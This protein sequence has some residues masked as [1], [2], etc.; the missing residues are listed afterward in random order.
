MTGSVPW[1]AGSAP[2]RLRAP[3]GAT[4]SHHHIYDDRFA[5]DP[6]AAL[7]PGNATVADYRLLQAQIGTTRNV[8]VQ[9]SSYGTDNRCL[10]DALAGFGTAAR[11]VAVVDE[12]VTDA[13][14]RAMDAA[15]VRGVRV[16]IARAGGPSVASIEALARRVAPLGWHVQIHTLADAYPALAPVLAG[17]PV[18]V[19]IDHLGR[20]PQPEGL[21]HAAWPALRALVDT[22]RCW[23]KIS[24]AYHDSRTG[25][26]AYADT[27][28]V[29]RAWIDAAPERLVWGTDWPH[30]SATAGEKPLP[31]D[32]VMF[33]LLESWAPSEALRQRILVENPA[34]LYGFAESD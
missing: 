24:G 23:V 25:A 28:A 18:Q 7:K 10:L 1:S 33:D 31:D 34:L 21:G 4:D 15:G 3:P 5:Y 8:V 20:L 14:L 12:S 2:A 26:P 30:P 9:P 16:N 19:V 11:G 29:A 27:S 17:L 13:E 32:A 22:G 6:A